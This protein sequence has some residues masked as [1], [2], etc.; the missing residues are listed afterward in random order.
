MRHP[1]LRAL[2]LPALLALLFC[3]AG[4][5]LAQSGQV[6]V[7]GTVAD[8]ASKASV[9]ARLRAIYGQDGVLDRITI[10]AV[11]TPP[12]WNNYVERLI[13]PEL[14]QIRRGQLK[15]DGNSVSLSG[16]VASEALRQKI[17]SDTQNSL[18]ATFASSYA[19]RVAASD[20]QLLD[21]TLANRIIEFESGKAAL[22]P[23]GRA[24]LD[25]M[26]EAMRGLARRS[27][28]L[29]GH[30]DNVGARAANLAL[31]QARAQSVKSYLA[32]RGIREDMM[33]VSG[34]GPDRPVAA[35]DTAEGR[36]RNRRI[37]FRLAR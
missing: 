22:T 27:V 25:E 21:T 37:E 26:A 17:T 12:N 34:L 2:A 10:G 23:A 13:T 15:I 29:I 19:L 35:N 32:E 6:Q 11:A 18:N 28:A 7:A 14:R 4:V 20:Q 5:A 31:S 36:A 3:C 8:E 33:T 9:L 16:E 24:I 30:T 1:V